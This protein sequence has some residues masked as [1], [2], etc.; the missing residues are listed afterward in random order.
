MV[1]ALLSVI[2]QWS[3]CSKQSIFDWPI[4]PTALIDQEHPSIDKLTAWSTLTIEKLTSRSTLTIE[5]QT[6][7]RATTI[8]KC[9]G[10]SAPTIEKLTSRSTPTIEIFR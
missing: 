1:G 10:Q 9:K 8:E 4:A 6:A 2:F 3:E 5:K 7:R